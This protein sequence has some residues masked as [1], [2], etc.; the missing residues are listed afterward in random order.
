MFDLDGLKWPF[1]I[2]VFL[3]FFGVYKFSVWISKPKEFVVTKEMKP[4]KRIISDGIKVDTV[5]VYKL[6]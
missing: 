2:I 5:L 6:P 4:E 3:L 1:R